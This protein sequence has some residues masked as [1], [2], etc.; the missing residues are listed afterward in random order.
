MLLLRSFSDLSAHAAGAMQAPAQ[1]ME[2]VSLV[3]W[4]DMG[5]LALSVFLL[6]LFAY[7]G[8]R[9][10]RWEGLILLASYGVYL[11][12]RFDLIPVISFGA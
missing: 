4:T 6:G 5:A 10:A 3:T 9:L 11:G 12:I 1:V 2:A 8:R 7:T